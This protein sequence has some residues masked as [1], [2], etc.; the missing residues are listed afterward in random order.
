M[1]KEIENPKTIVDDSKNQIIQRR[2]DMKI[3]DR[4]SKKYVQNH[5]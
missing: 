1:W 4:N 5:H 3:L 2:S